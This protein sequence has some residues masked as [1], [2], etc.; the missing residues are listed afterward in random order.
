MPPITQCTRLGWG[1]S[2]TAETREISFLLQSDK[3]STGNSRMRMHARAHNT[4][5]HSTLLFHD[6][7]TCSLPYQSSQGQTKTG[8]WAEFT[9][10]L[11]H[12]VGRV[13]VLMT[14]TK[15]PSRSFLQGCH[16]AH[17]SRRL[18]SDPCLGFFQIQRATDMPSLPF[19]TNL[20]LYM[21]VSRL[22]RL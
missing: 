22:G 12:T 9:N 10:G 13:E 14:R 4:H 15:T 17:V 5:A 1:C 3:W 7:K 6:L 16:V 21:N 8:L 20:W 2:K 19:A 11:M 18:F